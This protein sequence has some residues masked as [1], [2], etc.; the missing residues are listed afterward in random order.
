[1]AQPF[2]A[3]PESIAPV[4]AGRP[5]LVDQM[6]TVLWPCVDQV[7]SR[8]GIAPPSD[9]RI[10]ADEDLTSAYYG[11]QDNRFRGGVWRLDTVGVT[12]VRLATSVP[13]GS[14]RAKPWGRIDLVVRDLPTGRYA[15]TTSE[16]TQSGWERG[17]TL[18]RED[19]VDVEYQGAVG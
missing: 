6:S 3:R 10:H 15:V 13:P 17:P 11:L 9:V 19:Y 7:A 18:A 12:Y 16:R 2:L 5:V 4:L 14:E 1:V 8:G